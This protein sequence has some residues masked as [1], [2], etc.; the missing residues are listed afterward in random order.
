MMCQQCRKPLEEEK[1]TIIVIEASLLTSLL[2]DLVAAQAWQGL[3]VHR[4]GLCSAHVS[5]SLS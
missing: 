3:P 5:D 1:K 2:T 4:Q